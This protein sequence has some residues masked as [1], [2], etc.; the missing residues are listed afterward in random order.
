MGALQ[1]WHNFSKSLQIEKEAPRVA[2]KPRI[3][4]HICHTENAYS[5][6]QIPLVRQMDTDFFKKNQ[7]QLRLSVAYSV[8][9]SQYVSVAVAIEASKVSDEAMLVA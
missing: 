8:L 2:F 9:Q 7:S 4:P 3:E 1:R 5:N 6:S